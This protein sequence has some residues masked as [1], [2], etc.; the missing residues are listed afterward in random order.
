MNKA[1]LLCIFAAAIAAPAQAQSQGGYVG[2]GGLYA[3]T[4]NARDF[5][6]A[7]GGTGADRNADGMKL[8]GG[9]LWRQYGIEAGYYDLGTYEVRVG[10]A[11]RDDFKVS[12]FAVSG[13]LALPVGNQFTLNAKAGIAFTRVDYRCYFSCG[14]NFVNT[15]ESNVAG[16]L[17]AGIAWQLARNF[18]LRAD[19]EH[20]G[21]VTHSV[22]LDEALY[23]YRVFSLSGQINF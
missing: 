10:S 4:E 9:Y 7:Y 16:L 5:A 8:Y 1:L 18:S 12:A 17:G 6:R 13:V 15:R 3:S 11:K 19:F 14:G 21:D 23:P 20:L 22:G 2:A